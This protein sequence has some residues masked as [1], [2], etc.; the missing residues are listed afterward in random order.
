MKPVK[1]L[2]LTGVSGA[3]GQFVGTGS[4]LAPAAAGLPPSGGRSQPGVLSRSRK[5]AGAAEY[6]RRPISRRAE[7]DAGRGQGGGGGRL[8]RHQLKNGSSVRISNLRF[9]YTLVP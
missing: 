3:A 2:D 1:S 9:D 8:P 5:L 4:P 7:P 6:E